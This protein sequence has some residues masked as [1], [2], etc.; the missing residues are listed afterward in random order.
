MKRLFPNRIFGRVIDICQPKNARYN[1]AMTV[2]MGKH[3]DS[4]VVQ[5]DK[6][7]LGSDQFLDFEFLEV[8]LKF[9]VSECIR[10][11]KDQHVGSATF[12]PLTTIKSKPIDDSL[13]NLG[14][15][16]YPIIDVLNFDKQFQRYISICFYVVANGFISEFFQPDGIRM[17]CH[18]SR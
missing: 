8:F 11:L 13:R 14:R 3:L 2:A 18:S 17:L 12:I 6:T 9:F 10:Y 1:V 7:A 4:I 5:D 16:V 15:R